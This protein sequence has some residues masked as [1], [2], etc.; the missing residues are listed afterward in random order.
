MTRHAIPLVAED[1]SQFSRLLARQLGEIGPSPS[2]LSL[3]N[4]LAR[5]SGFRNYQ[6]LKSAHEAKARLDAPAPPEAVD[7]RLV[8]RALGWFDAEGRLARWPTKRKLQLLCLW[9][10]WAVLPAGIS[11]PEKTVNGLLNDGH[12]FGDPAQLR[13]ELIG[14]GMA[15]RRIDG[16]D[17]RRVEQRPPA[18]A[19]ALIGLV[20]ARRG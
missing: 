7:H 19:R 9:P 1:I 10:L 13:R 4:M 5:A 18:E 3:M 16:S 15:T 2:H 20:A 8:E 12:L 6:H 17:Y 11:M 14:L